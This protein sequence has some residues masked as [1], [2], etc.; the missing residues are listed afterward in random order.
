MGEIEVRAL[1]SVDFSVG[2]G[3]MVAIMGASGSGKSTMLNLIGALD[4]PTEGEYLLDGEPVQDLDEYDLAAV[5]N[6]KIGFV[7]QSF[8]LLARDTALENVELP[9]VYAGQR[10][11]TRKQKAARALERVGLG[12][13]MDH[14]PNQL[15]GGQQ[16]RVSIARAIVNEPLLLLADE[17]TGALDSETTKQVMQLFVEL[18]KQGMTVVLVTHDP[19]IAGYAE[20]VVSFKDGIIVSNE[21]RNPYRS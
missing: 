6:R 3:E 14:L 20:R 11:G 7:F 18:H 13:R 2:F 1:K 17:P 5:R 9:M 16:Q 19:N 21:T 10:R 12:D 8:N 4:R 15:S